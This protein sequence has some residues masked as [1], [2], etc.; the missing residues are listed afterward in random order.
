MIKARHYLLLIVLFNLF[1]S[2]RAQ[3]AEKERYFNYYQYNFDEPQEYV[4]KS[5]QAEEADNKPIQKA[6]VVVYSGLSIGQKIRIP[7]ND[8]PKSIDN[9]WQLNYYSDIQLF[10]RETK[11][12]GIRYVDLNFVVKDQVRL[13]GH[14][15]PGLSNSQGKTLHEET[16]LK[17]GI[18]ITPNLINKTRN[19]LV[20]YFQDKGF[21]NVSV[22]FVRTPAFDE[23]TKKPLA[24]FENFDIIVNK[25]PK[26][27]IYDF[28][29]EGNAMLS[30]KELRASIKK[31]KRRYHKLN[32]F[33]SSKYIQTK[34]DE[35]K[36]NIISKYLSSGFRDARI[37]SDS[38][39]LINPKRVNVHVSVYEG[40]RYYWRNISWKGN[41]KYSNGVLDTL[42]GIKKGSV[43][44]QTL[45][46]ERL[47]LVSS[48]SGADIQS[49]YMDDGYLFFQM[50]PVETGVFNALTWKSGLTKGHRQRWVELPGQATT[51]LPTG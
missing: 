11:E 2:G 13:Y 31:L 4:I 1:W 32:I 49:L 20:S 3:T 7:G 37:I 51:K 30:D 12:N 28:V 22:E 40:N 38:V 23:K 18:Y 45:L 25:G 21:Y 27:K 15:F 47:G 35:E 24:G 41:L 14:R 50:T 5:I 16:G 26:V 48:S 33:A 46:D 19:K 36:N 44:N 10:M 34:F 6:L 39:Q 29:F 42:L 17:R 8:I 9:L 43:F